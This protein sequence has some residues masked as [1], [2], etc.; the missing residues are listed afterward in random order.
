M[1]TLGPSAH[2][3]A[4]PKSRHDEHSASR[5][6]QN[7]ASTGHAAALWLPYDNHV[8]RAYRAKKPRNYAEN[9]FH[10]PKGATDAHQ[11]Q[12]LVCL[13]PKEIC[14]LQ[15]RTTALLHWPLGFDDS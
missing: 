6:R 5:F 1:Y 14:A 2:E 13:T 12:L 4:R 15:S 10:C 11:V 3:R 8:T 7:S 9:P